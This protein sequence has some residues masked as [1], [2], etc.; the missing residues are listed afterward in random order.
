LAHRGRVA[1]AAVVEQ[2]LVAQREPPAVPVVVPH[3]LARQCRCQSPLASRE[4]FEDAAAD[5]VT[6]VALQAHRLQ[7]RRQCR[8]LDAQIATVARQASGVR[9]QWRSEPITRPR[10]TS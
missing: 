1:T 3:P 6:V 9:L 5:Q 2:H 8:Q 4:P 10:A 7:A